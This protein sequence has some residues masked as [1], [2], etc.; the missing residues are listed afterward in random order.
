[1]PIRHIRVAVGIG[2]GTLVAGALGVTYASAGAPDPGD[3]PINVEPS[4]A[5]PGDTVAVSGTDC[6]P[7]EGGDDQFV[8]MVL[9]DGETV[10]AE[11]LAE[12]NDEGD[13]QD[14]IVV[15]EDITE[16]TT[17]AVE[18]TC[19]GLGEA[20]A[21]AALEIVVPTPPTVV[22]TTTT[23]TTTPTTTPTPTAPPPVVQVP[24]VTG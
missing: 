7:N 23:T 5:A 15:P 12:G 9:L 6:F 4:S 2:V 14:Q 19:R 3:I 1:M 10:I 24:T 17:L 21:L 11:G 20:F 16:D 8:D 22:T 18:A 13:W